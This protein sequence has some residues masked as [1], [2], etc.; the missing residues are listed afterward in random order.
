MLATSSLLNP[1]AATVSREK[2][3]GTGRSIAS[4]TASAFLC[5]VDHQLSPSP[6]LGESRENLLHRLDHD[7][8]RTARD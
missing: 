3:G 2:D 1:A 6:G 8:V 4:R 7:R 5:V